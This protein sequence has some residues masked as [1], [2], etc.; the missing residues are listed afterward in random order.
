MGLDMYLYAIRH[1][2]KYSDEAINKKVWGLFPKIKPIDN[3]NTAEIKLE[4]AYWRKVNSIHKWFVDNV[5]DGKDDCGNY[6]VERKKLRELKDTIKKVLT[7]KNRVALRLNEKS[8]NGTSVELPPQGG[9]FFGGTEIDEYYWEN[10]EYTLELLNKILEGD[11]Y[12]K[13][14]FEYHSSW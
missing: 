12:D 8:L 5:Q 9:F 1:T 6:C 10:L 7:D 13:F 2:S 14:E 11:A 3:I 4:I